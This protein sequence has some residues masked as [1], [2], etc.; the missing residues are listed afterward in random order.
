MTE[1]SS[2][3]ATGEINDTGASIPTPHS[4]TQQAH[5]AHRNLA[6]QNDDS[7]GESLLPSHTHN[8]PKDKD[9]SAPSASKY[10][11]W[12]GELFA[13]RYKQKKYSDDSIIPAVVLNVI[14]SAN[15]AF[16]N[17]EK[18]KKLNSKMNK[19]TNI[20]KKEKG[21]KED[22]KTRVTR[23][24]FMPMRDYQ[25]WFAKDDNGAYIGTE[26]SREWTEAELE[27]EFGAYRPAKGE[28][29]INA[30]GIDR[31]LVASARGL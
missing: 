3:N 7:D 14:P 13:P 26:P 8:K 17:I 24:V 15:P 6:K 11:S 29:G 23:V 20:F 18:E 25:K 21:E 10:Q 16:S 22:G 30:G 9:T 19:I 4:T 28:Q 27:E 5:S 2:R 31:M 12:G 1:Q